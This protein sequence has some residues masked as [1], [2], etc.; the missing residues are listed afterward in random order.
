VFYPVVFSLYNP[1]IVYAN[2]DVPPPVEQQLVR[3]CVFVMKGTMIF[4]LVSFVFVVQ[5]KIKFQF[6]KIAVSMP[7]ASFVFPPH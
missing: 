1:A 7:I 3:L 2:Q 5:V 6:K 4:F